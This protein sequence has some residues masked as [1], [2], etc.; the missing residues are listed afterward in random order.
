MKEMLD[1]HFTIY[2]ESKDGK[3]SGMGLKS[4]GNGKGQQVEELNGQ[5]LLK[6]IEEFPS[7]E[8]LLEKGN[9]LQIYMRDYFIYTASIGKIGKEGSYGEKDVFSVIE[10]TVSPNVYDTLIELDQ[11]IS[12]LGPNEEG[13]IQ[14]KMYRFYGMDKYQATNVDC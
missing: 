11:K 4:F 8:R 6:F 9:E 12:N 14:K 10:E 2:I 13:K 3:V 5:K 1:D 7:V